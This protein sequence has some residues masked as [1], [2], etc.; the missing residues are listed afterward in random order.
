MKEYRRFIPLT[1]AACERDPPGIFTYSSIP[2]RHRPGEPMSHRRAATFLAVLA[3][4]TLA[5]AAHAATLDQIRKSGEIRLGYRTDAPPMAF[6]DEDGQPSGYSV[7]LCRRIAAAVKDQLKLSE[8]KVTFVPLKTE[9]RID[10]IVNNKADIECGATTMTLSR[11]EKVDFTSMTFLTGGS[12]LSL[13]GSGIDTVARLAGKSVAVV[14]GTTSQTALASYLEKNLI[15]TKVVVVANREEAMK[16]LQARQV[17][18]F[19]TD[20]I[21]LIGLLMQARDPGAFS[22]TNDLFSF[23]PYALVV[24]RN[25]A[26]F[27][28]V[29]DRALAQLYRT[30]Q[31]E[32]VY[33]Q[34]FGKAGLRPSP[35]LST[36]YALGALPE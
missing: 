12:V 32:Q 34:S 4:G 27:R 10:A 24:R 29:A 33:V 18:A 23:E 14:T 28:L 11:Q 21:V 19:A 3:S 2:S 36:V 8:L 20:Q 1:R 35:V 26:D 15:D 13:A 17:D 7:E 22:I 5:A 25:D 9:E 6:N 31:I 16:Q 30:G